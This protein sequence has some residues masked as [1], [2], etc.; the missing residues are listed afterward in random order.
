MSSRK[1]AQMLKEDSIKQ[2]FTPAPVEGENKVTGLD[3]AIAKYTK[4]GQK[5]FLGWNASAAVCEI[6]RRYK[7]KKPGFTLMMTMTW[8]H[9]LNLVACGLIKKLISTNCSYAAPS[10]APS[11]A[12]QRAFRE[13]SVEI[14]NWSLY[15]IQQ[16]LM[17]AAL[18]VGFMPTKSIAGSSMAANNSD[19]FVEMTDPFDSAKKIGAVKALEPDI[20]IVHALAADQSGNTILSKV[21][22]D[23]LWGPRAS[24]GGVLVTAEKIVSTDF[25]RQNAG[26]VSIPGY[27]VKSVSLCPLGAHPEGHFSSVA[28][29]DSYS[30]DYEFMLD[31]KQASADAAGLD[32]WL[33]QWVYSVKDHS[34]YT[35]RLGAERVSLLKRKFNKKYWAANLSTG[36]VRT[37][38][39]AANRTEIMIAAAAKKIVE[40][41]K[42]AGYHVL[43]A[44][45]GIPGMAA[46]LAY[47]QLREMGI[48]VELA[49]GSGVLGYHPRPGDPN[50]LNV[51]N[52]T[53]AKMLMDISDM[54]GFIVSGTGA[55]CLSVI[56]AAQIDERGNIN[57]TKVGTDLYISG[58]GGNNDNACGARE[59]IVVAAQS[60]RRC[61]KAVDYTTSR[62]DRIS[63]LVTSMGVF[64]K[65][66]D[67]NFVLSECILDEGAASVDER[68]SQI[69]ENCGWAIRKAGK[70]K[71]IEP[72]SG[73]DIELLRIFDPQGYL[74]K[75]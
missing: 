52:A 49:L 11:H 35:G 10:P 56:G 17:A 61:V 4:P 75:E 63:T 5:I 18:G 20:A 70:I 67:G 54:Y 64:E 32:E 74:L 24:S 37:A 22:Q 21:S 33:N 72:P 28:E 3:E 66:A 41:V 57:T 30:E 60:K 62:G 14:E 47:Y 34:E 8:D 46:W 29:I 26:L 51:S 39:K 6:I 13:G 43:L 31:Q 19:S 58:S 15:S 2:I 7:G 40:R 48:N 9:S 53:T 73:R 12:I 44:G 25:I 27:L 42:E 55:K 65:A 45:I 1:I 23:T 16:R 36:G 38:A 50:L 71:V 69:Q 68:A 59:V